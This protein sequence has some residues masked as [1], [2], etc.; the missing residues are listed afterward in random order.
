MVSK[1]LRTPSST[2]A[3]ALGVQ[4]GQIALDQLR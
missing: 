4:V 2:V 1:P 3:A